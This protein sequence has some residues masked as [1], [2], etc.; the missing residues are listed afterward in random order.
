MADYY[1]T[2]PR[3]GR[4]KPISTDGG[5][6]CANSWC[7]WMSESVEYDII[8]LKFPI[9]AGMDFIGAEVSH[10]RMRE[11]GYDLIEYKVSKIDGIILKQSRIKRILKEPR[12]TKF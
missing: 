5:Y 12:S 8:A 7:T 1:V 6:V 11:V 3:C 2:C 4:E 10:R 9:R